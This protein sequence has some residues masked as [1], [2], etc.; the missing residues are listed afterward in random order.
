MRGRGFTLL[1]VLVA[2]TVLGVLMVGLGQGVRLSLAL[3]QA[4]TR[5]L[6]ETAELDAGARALRGLLLLRWRT[7]N[8]LLLFLVL[9]YI[10][11]LKFMTDFVV[12]STS[13]NRKLYVP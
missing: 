3:W 5:R 11:P 12:K 7:L 10:Y 8:A 4:Q 13:D 2:L 1:E 9:I 6:A